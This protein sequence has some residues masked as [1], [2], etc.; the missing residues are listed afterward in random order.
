[1]KNVK[2]ISIAA[3]AVTALVTTAVYA[4]GKG[5][6]PK[7]VD[8][9]FEGITGTYDRGAVQRGYQVFEAVCKSCH[10]L[11]YF[12]FRNLELIGF[13]EAQIKA[14]AAQY[15][16]EIPGEVDAFGDQ[17]IRKGLPKDGFPDLYPN[18]EKAVATHGALPPDLS[19]M[20]KARHDGSNYLYS[21]L[22]G[23]EGMTDDG[24]YKNPYYKGGVISMAPPLSDGFPEY[25]DGTDST[26]DQMAKDVTT[27]LTWVAEPHMESHKR[28]GIYVI[29][30]LLIMTILSYLS[31]KKIWA[32]VK[33]G[34]DVMPSPDEDD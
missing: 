15:E 5:K 16:M 9:S 10:E 17:I 18:D 24:K 31:M 34:E 20:T 23:Y 11:K 22:T 8:W 32:P 28:R 26:A 14:L 3:L 1:M 21:L 4:A 2:K 19:L 7:Q 12:K 33:R 13:P 30:F 29:S 25:M 27:F 6:K